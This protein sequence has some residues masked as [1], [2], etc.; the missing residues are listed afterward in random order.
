[1][2]HEASPSPSAIGRLVPPHVGVD[3]EYTKPYDNGELKLISVFLKSFLG[4]TIKVVT[5]FPSMPG[6]IV[7]MLCTLVGSVSETRGDGGV[8]LLQGPDG[9]SHSVGK[10]QRPLYDV[11]LVAPRPSA[12]RGV[13][14]RSITQ[15]GVSDVSG[16]SDVFELAATLKASHLMGKV[17]LSTWEEI[18]VEATGFNCSVDLGTRK[19]FPECCV[20]PTIAAPTMGF[21]T[22]TFFTHYEGVVRTALKIKSWKETD[23]D[24]REKMSA[25]V[26]AVHFAMP[27]VQRWMSCGAISDYDRFMLGL[28]VYIV[29]EGP[30][31]NMVKTR[32]RAKV[33]QSMVVGKEA[34]EHTDKQAA[35]KGIRPVKHSKEV[36][37]LS[38]SVVLC[39]EGPKDGSFAHRDPFVKKT[40]ATGGA[41]AAKGTGRD[42][43]LADDRSSSFGG[44]A[45]L[46]RA[47]TDVFTRASFG[48]DRAD[49]SPAKCVKK[50]GGGGTYYHDFQPG[51]LV[52][53]FLLGQCVEAIAAVFPSRT[54]VMFPDYVRHLVEVDHVQNGTRASRNRDFVDGGQRLKKGEHFLAPLHVRTNHWVL[55]ECS[56]KVIRIYD[57]LRSH[58]DGEAVEFAKILAT[59]PGFEEAVVVEDLQWPR[60]APSSND[61]A[62]FVTRAALMILS[63]CAQDWAVSVFSR[64]ELDE[65][66]PHIDSEKGQFTRIQEVQFAKRM[67]AYLKA[68]TPAE[69]PPRL[70]APT[71]AAST[72]PFSP[73]P[74]VGRPQ[75]AP[76]EKLCTGCNDRLVDGRCR[77][78][79]SSACV[80]AP[81][82]S[83]TVPAIPAVLKGVKQ[84]SVAGAKKARC[85]WPSCDAVIEV[86]VQCAACNV[87][88]CDKHSRSKRGPWRCDSCLLKERS[89]LMATLPKPPPPAL[90]P[91]EEQS[92]GFPNGRVSPLLAE[93]AGPL[94]LHLKGSISKVLHPLAEKGIT[95]QCRTEHLKL[96][97]KI[98]EAPK[99]MHEWPLARVAL[100]ML[101]RGRQSEEWKWATVENKSG[102]LAAALTRL[103]EYTNGKLKAVFLKHS[104]EWSDAGRHI[105]RLA[106]QTSALG[107]AA[108]TESEMARAIE[109]ATDPDTKAFLILLWTTIGRSGDVSQVKTSGLTLGTTDSNGDM[110]VKVFFERGKVIGKVDP[111]H[112]H[113][114]I[115]ARWAKFLRQWLA[116]KTT[117][118]LFQQPSKKARA[119]FLASVRVHIRTVA[120]HCDLR[121]TRRGAAQL[122]AESGRPL[123]DILQFTRHTDLGML[124]RYL[125][126]GA[127]DSMEAVRSRAAAKALW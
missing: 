86:R 82:R 102:L 26:G 13:T 12:Q 114:V 94:L 79:L 116:G 55:L 16:G 11:S 100:E 9:T 80:G 6:S 38:L 93:T 34:S 76:G 64:A 91:S 10:D 68:K 18:S 119:K 73:T 92:S 31:D 30:T 20:P 42:C 103:S 99:E 24:A 23:H 69:A 77:S 97:K 89:Y 50:V 56:P 113:T 74:P 63:G 14:Q 87:V 95:A 5:D 88:F 101:E 65:M 2:N 117:V 39:F 123:E 111:Y 84:S 54:R 70:P 33:W 66:L 126:F 120:P 43:K 115:P 19:E 51:A 105:R 49:L 109:T 90:P 81:A 124:R 35:K 27:H 83:P 46:S 37:G 71:F 57:S 22:Q 44:R 58:T 98:S 127:T 52:T 121:S 8:L 110:N 75:R 104:Q 61:C 4:D 32:L 96:L 7:A 78:Q 29:D 59:M 112:V 28:E 15:S 60:Q 25:K 3:G 21:N 48:G 118:H 72:V 1:M 106:R 67:A 53:D 107:L 17:P 36:D 108:M 47:K 85:P 62:M 45:P 122:M 125:R 41:P 40:W